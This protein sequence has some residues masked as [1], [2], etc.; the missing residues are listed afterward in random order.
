M[1]FLYIINL[2]FVAA[3]VL[4][5]V[6]SQPPGFFEGAIR[7]FISI[8][9]DDDMGA[10]RAFSVEP[11]VISRGKGE[12]QFIILQI[13]LANIHMVAVTGEVVQR[14][15]GQLHLFLGELSSR[16]P[17][18]DQLFLDLG[19]ICLAQRDVQ[20][21]ADGFQVLDIIGCLLDEV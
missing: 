21:I 17:A 5:V 1:F 7:Q 14:L 4:G 9:F 6:G 13:V 19:Q 16:L 20:G 18:L 12:G 11:P 2:Y 3:S 15:A 10:R 8:T